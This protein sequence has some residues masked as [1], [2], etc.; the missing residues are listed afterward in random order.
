MKKLT[1]LILSRETLQTLDSANLAEAAAGGI[2]L[3]SSTQV[4]TWTQWATCK[5]N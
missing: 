5:Q 3:T 1:K 2:N 4:P